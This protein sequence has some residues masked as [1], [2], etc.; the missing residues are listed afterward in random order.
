MECRTLSVDEAN[1]LVGASTAALWL[2]QGDALFRE[3]ADA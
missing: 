3:D 2:L 1:L